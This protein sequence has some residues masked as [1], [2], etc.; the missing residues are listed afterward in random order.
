MT[1]GGDRNGFYVGYLPIPR[2]HRVFLFIALPVAL[3]GMAVGAAGLARSV[4]PW[5]SGV[6]QAGEASEFEGTLRLDPYPMLLR[7]DELGVADAWLL[8][9]MGKFGARH[10][11]DGAPG[12]DG[13]PVAIRGREL[14]RDGRRMIEIDPDDPALG[15][16]VRVLAAQTPAVRMEMRPAPEPVTL[17]G[18]IVDSKCYL[19]AM[20]PGAG[21]GHKACA[22]L[23]ISGGIPPV[24]VTRDAMGGVAYWLLTDKTG[25]G[26]DEAD[27]D[28]LRPVIAEPVALSGRAGRLGSWRVLML[29][30]LALSRAGV[31]SPGHAAEPPDAP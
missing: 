31:P 14:R 4:P 30:S 26:L 23:C 29:D 17:A 11:F 15:P 10:R 25:R 8:V 13:A 20:K 3:L 12:L 5:G 28:A 1:N 22:T 24:L 9:E 19:G 27:L 16:S 7:R 2:A 6:W 18:E 21:R